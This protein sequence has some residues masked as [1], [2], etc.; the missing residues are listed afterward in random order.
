[1]LEKFWIGFRRQ[2]SLL[3]NR[4]QCWV[5]VRSIIWGTICLLGGI[6]VIPD[7]VEVIKQFPCP[8]NIRSLRRF[9]GIVGFYARFTPDFFN[10]AAP[11]HK[12]KGKGI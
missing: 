5:L 11:L 9:V 1:M 12:I 8:C 10:K 6:R 7:T 2:G 4:R 3:T